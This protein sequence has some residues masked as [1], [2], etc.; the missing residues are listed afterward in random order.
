[1]FFLLLITNTVLDLTQLFFYLYCERSSQNCS[2]GKFGFNNVESWHFTI[3]CFLLTLYIS[4]IAAY[5][6]ILLKMR[7]L[8]KA[9]FPNNYKNI[10]MRFFL[11]FVI[12]EAFLGF[13]ASCYYFIIFQLKGTKI[14]RTEE[15][16]FY[17][18]EILLIG[19]LSFISLRPSS[20][21]QD[22]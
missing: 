21:D 4:I 1:M 10:R 18:T 20:G 13:R 11:L 16:I 19:F 8:F 22:N 15:T 2:Y 12:Y 17:S 3:S 5:I 6:A 7:K 14:H 9:A